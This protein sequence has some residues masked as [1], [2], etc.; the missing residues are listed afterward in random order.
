[1]N[2]DVVWRQENVDVRRKDLLA[3]IGNDC[4]GEEVIDGLGLIY[5]NREHVHC[6][7]DRTK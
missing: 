4:L 2:N 1:M 5:T 7:V 6:P 3:V